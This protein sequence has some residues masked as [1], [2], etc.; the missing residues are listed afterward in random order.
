MAPNQVSLLNVG[1]VRRH[2]Q[3]NTV[4]ETK[5]MYKYRTGDYVWLSLTERLFKKRLPRNPPVY[6]VKDLL[7]RP[8][9]GAFYTE[10]LQKV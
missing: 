5:Q 2:L 9:K 7:D 6:T 1:L 8:I 10:E 4:K 3:R